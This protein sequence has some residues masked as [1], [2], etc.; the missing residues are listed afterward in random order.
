MGAD[1]KW[2]RVTL[3]DLEDVITRIGRGDDDRIPLVF[4]LCDGDEING[5]P[6][7]SVIHALEANGICYTGSDAPYYLLTTSKITMKAAFDN[8][9]V[10]TAAWEEITN[11]SNSHEGLFDRIGSPAILKPAV[12]GGS[13]GL[14]IKNV[15]ETYD[16][17]EK[18]IAEL[19]EGYHGWTLTSGGLLAEQYIKGPEYTALIIGSAKDPESCIIYEPVERVFHSSLPETEQ[20]L[21]FDRL[22]EIY[23]DESQM[24]NADHFYQYREVPTNLTETLKQLTLEAYCAVEGKGYGR[25]D[26]RMDAQTGK[27]Y[28]LEVNAQCGLSEDED[29]TSIGAILRLSNKSFEAMVSEIIEEAMQR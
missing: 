11:E 9:S 24:P 17:L 21:S 2:Q 18:R 5:A 28:V 27:L 20:F 25:V 22:W 7:I 1:W 29:Y 4:N 19:D 13:M 6:G 3:N 10:A 14:T 15:L 23:D 12:S 26:I 8:A 16:A